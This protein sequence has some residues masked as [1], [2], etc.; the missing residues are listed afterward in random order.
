MKLCKFAEYMLVNF[1]GILLEI[2]MQA[3]EL[4]IKIVGVELLTICIIN[5]GAS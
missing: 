5:N 4:I 3:F 1:S 2:N